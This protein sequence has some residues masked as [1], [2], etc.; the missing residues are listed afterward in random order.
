MRN[1][2]N[3]KKKIEPR[4]IDNIDDCLLSIF[5]KIMDSS[6]YELLLIEGEYDLEKAYEAWTQIYEKFNT[7]IN[8]RSS[9]IRFELIKQIELKKQKFKDISNLLFQITVISNVNVINSIDT[10]E[11]ELDIDDY[12]NDI[13]EHGF[14][15]NKDKG[16]NKELERVKAQSKN[17]ISQINSESEKLNKLIGKKNDD[18]FEEIIEAVERDRSI[19]FN[20]EANVKKFIVA[21][22]LMIKLNKEKT[23]K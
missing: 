1:F 4:Y 7:G 14:R 10:D 12:I 21:Y 3:K 22:N 15:F 23:K 6:N 2:L 20:K 5:S 8:S 13:N 16:I 18:S 9:I 11:F 17:L 19:P